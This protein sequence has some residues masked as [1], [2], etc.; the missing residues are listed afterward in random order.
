[1]GLTSTSTGSKLL[2]NDI[3][4]LKEKCEKESSGGRIDN[5]F[6]YGKNC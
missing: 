3:E 6:V 1:M 2:K 5:T 4:E